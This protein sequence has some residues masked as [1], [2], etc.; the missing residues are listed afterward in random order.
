MKI[1]MTVLLL[2]GILLI[3]IQA[4][5]QEKLIQTELIRAEPVNIVSY[6]DAGAE[7]LAE[8]IA[9]L[10]K[11]GKLV[12]MFNPETGGM[13]ITLLENIPGDNWNIVGGWTFANEEPGKFFWG[14]EYELPLTGETWKV[15]KRF[16]PALY[17]CEGKWHW[18][19]SFEL[20]PEA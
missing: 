4:V 7:G 20:R 9:R 5:A 10:F 8:I 2:V 17:N 11:T 14:I 16:R 12:L 18:G 15:F 6:L 13:E 1:C 3:P 19:F